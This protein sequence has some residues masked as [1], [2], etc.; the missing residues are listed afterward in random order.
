MGRGQQQGQAAAGV[1]A[2]ERGPLGPGGGQDAADVVHLVV[3]GVPGRA[4]VREAVAEAVEQEQPG[5]R[6]QLAQEPGE[7]RVL[8][9]QPEVGRPPEQEHQVQVA[10]ADH[11]VGQPAPV[12]ATGVVE[13]WA[14]AHGPSL[15]NG[16]EPP[17][18]RLIHSDRQVR[19]SGQ[20]VM[21]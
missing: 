10:L 17:W 6:R 8:P 7:R 3:E 4:P 20:A 14:V 18:W 11:L 12:P 21:G 1:A 2:E 9:H 15:R 19:R 5:E 16:A 13:R